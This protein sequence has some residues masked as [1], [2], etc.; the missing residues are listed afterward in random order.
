MALVCE[1]LTTA[2]IDTLVRSDHP[3]TTAQLT[4]I[5]S[6]RRSDLA[7]LIDLVWVGLPEFVIP[8]DVLPVPAPQPLF[9]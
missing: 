1:D 6:G 7:W 2:A 5:R 9:S 4:A 3:A 8:L